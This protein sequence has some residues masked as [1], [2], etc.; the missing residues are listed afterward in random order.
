MGIAVKNQHPSNMP[1]RSSIVLMIA[2]AFA[3][4]SLQG[5]GCDKEAAK[6]CM[7]EK[8]GQMTSSVSGQTDAAKMKEALCKALNEFVK[9]ITDNS[10]CDEEEDGQKN[11]GRCQRN[12]RIVQD[13]WLRHVGKVR[14]S[15]QSTVAETK[16]LS[17][18][19]QRPYIL[20][21]TGGGQGCFV[22]GLFGKVSKFLKN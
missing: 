7:E 21:L 6:K 10:C 12:G 14:V 15:L 11:E 8:I 18:D 19:Q 3:A 2:F 9:C 17:E 5:C 4:L 20:F 16:T 22:Y 1:S 13:L